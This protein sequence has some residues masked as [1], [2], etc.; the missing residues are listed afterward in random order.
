MLTAAD[1][2]GYF[3]SLPQDLILKTASSEYP[4]NL[5]LLSTFSPVIRSLHPS[6][7]IYEI[8]AD[9]S[10]A[11]ITAVLSFLSGSETTFDADPFGSLLFAAILDISVILNRTSDL[12]ELTT[13]E[14]NFGDRFSRLS[15]YVRYVSPLLRFAVKNTAVFSSLLDFP[16][17][18]VELS[19]LII[20][21]EGKC[22]PTEVSKV[23]F[24]LKCARHWKE[25][26]ET[27][28]VFDLDWELI[29]EL[30]A[31]RIIT[32]P[33]AAELER[34]VSSFGLI[35]LQKT[36]REGLRSEVRQKLVALGDIQQPFSQLLA[37]RNERA[38]E[39]EALSG[40]LLLADDRAALAVEFVTQLREVVRTAASGLENIE[41]TTRVCAKAVDILSGMT[42]ISGK[43]VDRLQSMSSVRSILYPESGPNSLKAMKAL[44]DLALSMT[45]LLKEGIASP[46]LLPSLV[47]R[48]AAVDQS[49]ASLI[50]AP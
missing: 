20:S 7:S 35:K 47:R 34:V 16:T 28:V 38:Q 30:N 8:S 33:R 42:L 31:Y 9:L 29:S 43:M 21:C 50:P 1:L 27:G 39:R 3:S 23:E 24:L 40:A 19:A 37:D 2:R 41:K 45:R 18:S 10:S 12:V 15:P 11:G 44:D 22:F 26:P 17:F 36:I 14:S 6:V 13:T 46:E 32:H 48:L 49:L 5:R 25:V 4:T